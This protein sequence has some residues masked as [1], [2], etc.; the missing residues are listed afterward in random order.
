M[1]QP[2]VLDSF[3]LISFFHQEPGWETVRTVFKELG[4]AGEKA[5]LSRINWGEFYYIVQRRVGRAKTL[6]ALALIEQLPINVLSVDDLLISEAAEIKS[7]YPISYA[8]AF[9]VATARRLNARILTSD[10]EFKAVEKLVPVQ[11]LTG[12]KKYDSTD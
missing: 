12:K 3:A 8:D 6:E 9:C 10:P 2:V 4:E 7:E 5:A 11:W 1:K